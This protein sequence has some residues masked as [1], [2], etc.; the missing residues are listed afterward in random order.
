M[1]W[2][3]EISCVEKISWSCEISWYKRDP[4]KD[5]LSSRLGE[6][7]LNE[8]KRGEKKPNLES[9][10][11]LKDV[12]KLLSSVLLTSYCITFIEHRSSLIRIDD[13]PKGRIFFCT[14]WS[15]GLCFRT[16]VVANLDILRDL[17]A[18]AGVIIRRYARE[19]EELFIL[20]YNEPMVGDGHG[21]GDDAVG[22]PG[23]G[24]VVEVLDGSRDAKC[25]HGTFE[26]SSDL[27]FEVE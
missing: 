26:S 27:G 8:K 25:D 20:V 22:D 18:Y 4:E 5:E 9:V 3:E 12:E 19:V 16:L 6:L 1:P 23:P 2:I 24:H 15:N 7:N 10:R 13:A 17:P 14:I 21:P 11:T